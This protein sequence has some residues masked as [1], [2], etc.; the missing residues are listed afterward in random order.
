MSLRLD[1][2]VACG[3]VGAGLRRFVGRADGRFVASVP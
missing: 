3:S 2:S 1:A